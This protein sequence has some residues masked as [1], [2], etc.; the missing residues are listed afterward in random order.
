M[1]CDKSRAFQ[2][3]ATPPTHL[4]HSS[5]NQKQHS[6]IYMCLIELPNGQN[7]VFK[8][9]H[10]SKQQ[11][12]CNQQAALQWP[13]TSYSHQDNYS[14]QES[15]CYEHAALKRTLQAMYVPARAELPH[16]TVES[17]D[18]SLCNEGRYMGGCRGGGEGGGA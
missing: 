4:H 16:I 2:A 6:S 1:E 18:Q 7:K 13:K 14:K 15:C 11:S 12:C 8:P 3:P 17:V 9:R 5:T 10:N